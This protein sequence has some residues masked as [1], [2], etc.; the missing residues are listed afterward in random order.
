MEGENNA[1]DQIS[2][3][4]NKK[5]FDNN[6]GS[7]KERTDTAEATKEFKEESNRLLRG[8]ELLTIKSFNQWIEEAKTTPNPK[9]L[10]SEFFHEGEVCFLFADT[11]MGKSVLGIQCAQ[12]FAS[13]EVID[14]FKMDA[15]PQ[16]TLVID[17]E[18]SAKQ[19]E[20]RYSKQEGSDSIDHFHFSKRLY[21]ASI[22]PDADLPEGKKF[23]D[24]FYA[25]LEGY[26]NTY[27]LKIIV[28]DNITYLGDEDSEKSKNAIPLMKKLKE[29]KR[30][31]SV[32]ILALAHTPKRKGDSPLTVNDLAGSKMLSNFCDSAFA[33]GR[34]SQHRDYYIKQI[35]ARNTPIRYGEDNVCVCELIK[36]HNFL[37]FKFKFFGREKEILQQTNEKQDLKTEA[38]LLKKEGYTL[39]EIA[40]KIGVPRATISDWTTDIT[41]K[42]GRGKSKKKSVEGS[43]QNPDL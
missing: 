14:G 7:E 10:F 37:K 25:S 20:L 43:D 8:T 31:Y 39:D 1:I 42:K 11:N 26:I 4:F 28:V 9:M 22:N 30:K 13:G 19:Q 29:L 34:D 24:I 17:F 40:G 27:Q 23:E 38:R 16:N 21:R 6:G 32:T 3:P 41:K 15:E 2:P 5:I 18:L 36:E 33:I 12:S 35:K